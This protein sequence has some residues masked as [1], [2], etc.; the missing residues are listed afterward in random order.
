MQEI[1]RAL[2]GKT[3]NYYNGWNGSHDYFTIGHIE[4][5]NSCVR[6]FA[7]RGKGWGV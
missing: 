7:E 4:N 1:K 6:V 3:I 5:A 2:I